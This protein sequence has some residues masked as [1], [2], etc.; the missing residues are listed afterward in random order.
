MR[1]WCVDVGKAS[2]HSSFRFQQCTDAL[3]ASLR[4]ALLSFPANLCRSALIW[5][6]KQVVNLSHLS[7]DAQSKSPFF[8]TQ[9]AQHNSSIL[10]GVGASA[11]RTHHAVWRRFSEPGD[12]RW[13]SAPRSCA[14]WG[15]R[16]FFTH[17]HCRVWT[18]L[19]IQL[20]CKSCNN[21]HEGGT[22]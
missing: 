3:H 13:L 2:D 12:G 16:M 7:F 19:E 6:L 17:A 20:L 1:S 9:I 11:N 21:A 5:I 4:A 15:S 14:C 22:I 18:N 8:S 10:P